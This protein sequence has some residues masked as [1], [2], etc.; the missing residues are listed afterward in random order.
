MRLTKIEIIHFGKINEI[1]Y[2][3]NPDLAVFYGENEAGKSTTVAFIKQIMFGFHLKNNKSA[4]FEDYF[5]LSKASP[6]GGRLHFDNEGQEFI[7]QRT[8]ASG[9]SKK[10]SLKVYL[11]GQQVPENV[12]FDKIKNIDGNFYTDSF[13]FNQEM[14]AQVNSLSQNELMEQIYFLGA[15]QSDKLLKLRKDYADQANNLFKKTGRKPIINQLINKIDAQKMQVNETSQE[16]DD[17]QDLLL[18]SNKLEGELKENKVQL[19]QLNKKNQ[20]LLLIKQK[21]KN[22]DQYQSLKKQQKNVVFSGALYD[23]AQSLGLEIKNL[24]NSINSK[25][26]YLSQLKKQVLNSDQLDQMQNLADRKAEYL[27]WQNELNGLEKSS[28]QLNE[29]IVQTQSLNPDIAKVQNL[30]QAQISDL[31]NQLQTIKEQKNKNNNSFLVPACWGFAIVFLVLALISKNLAWVILTALGAG[32]GVWLNQNKQKPKDEISNFKQKYNIDPDG[33][34]LETTLNLLYQ[35]K[36]K[37]NSLIQNQNEIKQLQNQVEDYKFQVKRILGTKYNDQLNV[38]NNLK[39]ISQQIT[40]QLQLNSQI[41]QLTQE[42]DQLNSQLKIKQQDLLL[43]YNKAGVKGP[44]DFELRKKQASEQEHLQ[45]QLETLA[46]N[47]GDDLAK[48]QSLNQDNNSLDEKIS[49]LSQQIK[50]LEREINDLQAQLAQV[51]VKKSNLADSDDVFKQRQDLA[52]LE[53]QLKDQILDYLSDLSVSNWIARS[54]DLASNERFPKMLE[55]AKEYFKLLTG[56]RYVDLKLDK[57]LVVI[58]QDHKKKEVQFLS[59]G[60]SEQLY[61][62]LKLAFVQQISDEIS[63]P[64]LIDDAFVNFDN[65]RTEYIVRLIEKLSKNMQVLIFTHKQELAQEFNSDIIELSSEVK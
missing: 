45:L 15:A 46:N 38:A 41:Q 1:S 43:T 19:E 20:N 26:Q 24:E 59:R 14:L 36:A 49:D 60:T 30:N 33:F 65:Q 52:L 55:N 5:P 28:R 2:D 44:D 10:G 23:Q 13:I 7:L 53:S 62:A 50:A 3:L 42:I 16:F 61:F 6:M 29:E 57:K 18:Q 17:Y 35:I 64:I 12:F 63:L 8:Y 25:E 56:N 40:S 47:L 48:I 54:L 27:Q 4:F 11:D 34:N 58:D 21:L 9:D 37:Q 39:T 22:F 51:E 32:L 31:K